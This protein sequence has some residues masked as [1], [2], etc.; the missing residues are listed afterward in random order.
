MVRLFGIGKT[1]QKLGH[2]M[3]N[4][5]IPVAINNSL[6]C[7]VAYPQRSSANLFSKKNK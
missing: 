5:L 7:L 1:Q 4:D 6:S 3:V 2:E